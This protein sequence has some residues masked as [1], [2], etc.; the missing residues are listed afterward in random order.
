MGYLAKISSIRVKV[1]FGRPRCH[2]LLDD[3]DPTDAPD[4]LVLHLSIGWIVHPELR[5]GRAEQTLLGIGCRM[6]IIEP[7][8]LLWRRPN[9][10]TYGITAG[11]F[12]RS[13]DT[14]DRASRSVREPP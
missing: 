5:H 1:L 10:N 2:P 14:W 9:P 11:S 8:R 4:V 12:A 7:G 6:R 13:S 3:I